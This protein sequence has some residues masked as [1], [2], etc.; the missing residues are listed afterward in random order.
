MYCQVV[1][2]NEVLSRAFCP[3]SDSRN[4]SVRWLVGWVR[5]TQEFDKGRTITGFDKGAPLDHFV[6]F[7]CPTLRTQAL[8]PDNACVMAFGAGRLNFGL[9]ISMGRVE[10][11]RMCGR[12]RSQTEQPK[13]FP[14]SKREHELLPGQLRCKDIRWDSMRQ[15]AAE[16]APDHR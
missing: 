10:G 1:V 15:F 5:S 3:S 14:H 8:L 6:Y 12:T 7:F 13:D 4:D 16:C 9:N 11:L 2:T